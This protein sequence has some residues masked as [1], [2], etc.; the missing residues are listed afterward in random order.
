MIFTLLL[1]LSTALVTGFIDPFFHYHAPLDSLEYP[2]NNQRYQNDGIVNHFS[3]DALITGTSLAENFKTS[4]FDALFGVN[5]VKVTFSGGTYSEITSNL[6]R[7]LKANPNIRYVIYAIDEWFLYAGK[8]LILADGEYPTYLYDNDPFNDVNYLFNKDVFFNRT[9]QV[10]EFT[11]QGNR[12]TSFDDYSSWSF[13]TG[14]EAVLTKYTRPEKAAEMISLTPKEAQTLDENLRLNFL[15]LAK[16]YPNTQ[17]IFYFPPYS[18]INW[19]NHMQSGTLVR[20]VQALKLAT[21]I[22]LEA[23]NIQVFSFY[24]DSAL[25]TNLDLY[26]DQV[27]YNS[28]TNSLLLKRMYTGEYRLTRENYQAHWQDVLDF[29]LNYNYDS[30]FADPE[31]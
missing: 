29:Y 31:S 15:Q 13:P 5:S 25:C 28:Q 11:S 2:L 6:H 24:T 16:A 30:I 9:L 3:Y 26:N 18:I 17:F 21:E 27:H 14:R 19:D 1:L 8:D 12:T 23:D 20:N 7:A 22:L 4:E 10:L